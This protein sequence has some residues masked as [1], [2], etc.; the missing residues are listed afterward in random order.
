MVTDRQV[1]RLLE[2][3]EQGWSLCAAAKRAGMDEKTARHYRTEWKLPSQV[4]TDR[5][6]RTR[7]DPFAEVWGGIK[8][9]LAVAPGLEAKTLMRWLMGEYPGRFNTGQLRTLQ[10]HIKVWRAS[11]GPGKEIYFS[12]EHHPGKRSQSDFTHMS[13]LGVTIAGQHFSHM[14][15]HFVFTYSNWEDATIC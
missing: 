12:Q 10:R 2:S 8:E 5:H 7:V 14:C 1:R 13:E 6:W 9:K 4:R 11:E 15:F 3:L